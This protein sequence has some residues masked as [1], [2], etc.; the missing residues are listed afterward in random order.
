MNPPWINGRR[1]DLTWLVGSALVVPVGLLFVWGGASA[2]AVN[3]AVTALVGGPHVFSTFLVTYFDPRFRRA[4]R[5]VLVAIALLVPAA[6]VALTLTNYQGLVSFFVFAASIHVLQ[7]NAYLTD[8]YR[9]RG[10]TPDPAWSRL[11]DYGVLFLSFYPIASYKLVRGD[12][13][14]GDVRVLIPSFTKFPETYWTVSSAFAAVLG[15]WLVKTAREARRGFLN[16]PK[17]IL[18]GVTTTVAFLI[19][20]A[21]KGERL[22]LAFQAVNMWHSIQ[23]LAIVWLVLKI[24]KERGLPGSAWVGR[25]SGSGRAAWAFYG[26]CFAFTLALLGG[27]LMLVRANPLGLA[28]MQYYYMAVLSALF[29]HY[30]LDGYLFFAAGREE[31]RPDATPLAAPSGG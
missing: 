30:T 14:L 17:T 26:L 16:A 24:R 10:G 6:V 18:I 3:L 13:M 27:I 5:A 7:Q 12:F 29:I 8:V 4:N 28:P 9:R 25:V 20:C 1:W 11:L 22:E 21:E 2:D 19:P 15:G 31:A 23:Y